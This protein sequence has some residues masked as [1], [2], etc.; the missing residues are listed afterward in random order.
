MRQYLLIL[1]LFVIGTSQG[2]S[3]KK[4]LATANYSTPVINNKK[5]DLKVFP[6]PALNHIQISSNEHVSKVFVYDLIGKK[7]KSFLF[8]N[9][10]KYF[11]GDLRKGIYLVQLLDSKSK[12]LTT[13]RIRKN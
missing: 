3:Q 8:R 5:I 9:G 10:Q 13:K 4:L 7:V 1:A 6:N 2:L 12:I 11:V